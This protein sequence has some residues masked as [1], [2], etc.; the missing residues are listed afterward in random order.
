MRV[1][2]ILKPQA[3]NKPEQSGLCSD[4]RSFD[5][6][7]TRYKRERRDKRKSRTW[8]ATCASRLSLV[9]MFITTLANKKSECPYEHSD[10]VVLTKKIPTINASGEAKENAEPGTRIASRLS[11]V[12]IHY[13]KDILGGF[14]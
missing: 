11:L 5:E 7:D 12:S 3:K 8:N 4:V 13:K 6:K 14:V 1:W 9:R 10:W 2:L